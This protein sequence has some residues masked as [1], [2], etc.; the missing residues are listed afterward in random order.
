MKSFALVISIV[1]SLSLKKS[2]DST[3]ITVPEPTTSHG[4]LNRNS[5]PR[6]VTN[7]TLQ[8]ATLPQTTPCEA[9]KLN[10]NWRT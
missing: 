4:V 5:V 1:F 10:I 2:V 7:T 6:L 3:C 9:T 8:V